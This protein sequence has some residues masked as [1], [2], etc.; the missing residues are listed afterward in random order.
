MDF[1]A[2]FTCHDFNGR[3]MEAMEKNLW[4]GTNL[5]L[6]RY[7]EKGDVES[8]LNA[9]AMRSVANCETGKQKYDSNATLKRMQKN[10]HTLAE[11][12]GFSSLQK[13]EHGNV[14][15][16]GDSKGNFVS[17]VNRYVYEI[18][19]KARSP[20]VSKEDPW[21]VPLAVDL[22]R[23]NFRGKGITMAW[24]KR[25]DPRLPYQ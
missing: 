5:T 10:V 22:A 9:G 14:W 24:P 18:Y 4:R 20:L 25:A 17:G 11:C 3:V 16:W 21:M 19:V 6:L 23:V 1:W 8:Q 12:L 2:N 13:E 7:V 15:C